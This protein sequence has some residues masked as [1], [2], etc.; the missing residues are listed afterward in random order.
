MV[1]YRALSSI[2]TRL[3]LSLFPGLFCASG[4]EEEDTLFNIANINNFIYLQQY[5]GAIPGKSLL[6]F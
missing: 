3:S 6:E 1:L 2:A 5:Q 4:K